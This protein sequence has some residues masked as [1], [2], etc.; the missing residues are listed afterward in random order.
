VLSGRARQPLS[1]AQKKF[2]QLVR[3]IEELRSHIDVRARELDAYLARYA[4][5]IHPRQV[6]LAAVLENIIRLLFPHLTNP[7]YVGKHHRWL[8]RDAMSNYF[9]DLFDLTGPT[10]DPE[11]LKIFE[12]VNGM[13]LE[14]AAE[15]QAKDEL[16]ELEDL[17]KQAGVDVDLSGLGSNERDENS[18]AR[19]EELLNKARQADERNSKRG[20]PKGAARKKAELEKAR[21]LAEARTRDIGTLYRQLAKLLHPDLEQDPAIRPIKEAAMKELTAAYKNNDLHAMLRLEITWITREDARIDQITGEKLEVYNQVLSEQVDQL[22]GELRFVHLQPRYNP[23]RSLID[24]FSPFDLPPPRMVVND[25]EAELD[26]H[27]EIARNLASPNPGP[28][29]QDVLDEAES[30]SP[31]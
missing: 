23:L 18:R 6:E 26:H 8:L 14:K 30:M 3:R 13:S 9:N 5:E 15:V 25:L 27:R 24:P 2:N 22:M 29:L 4:R 7:R 11:L 17:F 10:N 19:F 20:R 12:V 16:A 21:Q 28:T 1:P 31:W